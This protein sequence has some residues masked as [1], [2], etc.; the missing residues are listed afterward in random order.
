[1]DVAL[2]AFLL[3]A[4]DLP[5]VARSVSQRVPG[6]GGASSRPPPPPRVAQTLPSTT[7]WVRHLPPIISHT[8]REAIRSAVQLRNRC[9][10]GDET[11]S[12]PRDVALVVEKIDALIDEAQDAAAVRDY[13][14]LVIESTILC[15]TTN[16]G[17]PSDKLLQLARAVNPFLDLHVVET[18]SEPGASS[19]GTT[20]LPP[21]F[22]QSD[23]ASIDEPEKDLLMLLHY[24]NMANLKGSPDEAVAQLSAAARKYG[25]IKDLD[26]R[27]ELLTETEIHIHWAVLYLTAN[28]SSSV[29]PFALSAD[30]ATKLDFER[31]IQMSRLLTL[32]EILLKDARSDQVCFLLMFLGRCAAAQEKP[33]WRSRMKQVLKGLKKTRSG[34]M[35]WHIHFAENNLRRVKQAEQDGAGRWLGRSSLMI[36]REEF[37]L[38]KVKGD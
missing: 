7:V 2:S 36:D 11:S 3:G 38:N 26:L 28:I 21:P 9:L 17:P 34:R 8:A 19:T 31:N 37:E 18:A 5:L 4:P 35:Q 29:A 25:D 32:C 27:K 23:L 15:L 6:M 12:G 24:C 13:V 20:S 16:H 22:R 14:V 33:W 10:A 30:S 1:M